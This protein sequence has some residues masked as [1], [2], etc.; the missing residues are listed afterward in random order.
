MIQDVEREKE[1]VGKPHQVITRNRGPRLA[2]KGEG[3][4]DLVGQAS[5]GLNY[6]E[7]NVVLFL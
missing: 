7:R 4:E 5:A 3:R 6:V 2:S 1:G